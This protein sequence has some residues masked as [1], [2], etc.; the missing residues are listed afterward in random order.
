M[1]KRVYVVI[2]GPSAEYEVS[3][4]TGFEIISHLDRDKYDC[5]AV[6]I[7]KN[8]EFYYS[9]E[10]QSSYKPENFD[11]PENCGKFFGPLSPIA[12]QEIWKDCDIAYLALHGEFGEDGKV[13]G[14]LDILGIPYTGSGVFASANGL[15]KVMS[16]KIFALHGITTPN[17]FVYSSTNPSTTTEIANAVGYPCFVKCPQSGSSRLMGRATDDTEL[18]NLLDQQE[19][20]GILKELKERL[21]TR[22][23]ELND[24]I[25]KEH[26]LVHQLTGE[27]IS[28]DIRATV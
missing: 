21:Y 16:Q 22:L 12:S 3:L 23:R 26:W 20:A 25:L 24:D 11:N 18:Q 10:F 14:Y 9:K 28:P 6:L 8:K 15:N 5:K 1:K 27:Y 4:K 19:Y 7:T 17:S 13:Q 2:G